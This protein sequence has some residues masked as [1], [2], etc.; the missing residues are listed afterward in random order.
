MKRWL[1]QPITYLG[2]Q[3]NFKCNWYKLQISVQKR[4]IGVASWV[5]VDSHEVRMT[6]LLLSL[7][8]FP[9][10]EATGIYLWLEV[11]WSHMSNVA[12]NCA[13]LSHKFWLSLAAGCFREY[14][15]V[16]SPN[17]AAHQWHFRAQLRVQT[18][19]ARGL[20]ITTGELCSSKD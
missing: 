4:S 10:Y 7:L 8:R 6:D 9:L 14:Q 11:V 19:P 13:K 20:N 3:Q 16:L 5:Q 1:F 17:P 12:P 15:F 18:S 2:K